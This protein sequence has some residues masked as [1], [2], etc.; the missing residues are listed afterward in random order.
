MRPVS[1]EMTTW[2]CPNCHQVFA[3]G[4]RKCDTCGKT[5]GELLF[6][7]TRD[8]VVSVRRADNCYEKLHIRGVGG[9]PPYSLDAEPIDPE[10][11]VIPVPPAQVYLVYQHGGTRHYNGP[12]M[13]IYADKESAQKS[14][15]Y[16]AKDERHSLARR[17]GIK[18]PLPWAEDD[19]EP[20]WG[21][22][23]Q[24]KYG[25]IPDWSFC[26]AGLATFT[27]EKHDVKVRK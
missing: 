1:E 22:V 27:I 16:W 23:H 4:T 17:L 10:P 14:V 25:P 3:P 12:L 24:G 20:E 8:A 15:I 26:Q 21:P 11:L 7:M 13:G 6:E 18:P 2:E 5:G 9:G 19:Q